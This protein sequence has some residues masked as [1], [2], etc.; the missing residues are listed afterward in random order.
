MK[1]RKLLTP[2]YSRKPGCNF[3]VLYQLIISCVTSINF[4]IFLEFKNGL[5]LILSQLRGTA[6]ILC[7]LYG[8]VLANSVLSGIRCLSQWFTQ[9][10]FHD[11]LF[12]CKC[13]NVTMSCIE[14]T[15]SE[16]GWFHHLVSDYMTA[17]CLSKSV[18][19]PV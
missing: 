15:G 14:H 11:R 13:C 12:P 1:S 10:Y 18:N 6:I 4:L 2:L 7:Y 3:T 17:F 16:V 8:V 9:R 5:S 19:Q